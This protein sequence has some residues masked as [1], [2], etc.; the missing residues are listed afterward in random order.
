[1]RLVGD[2]EEGRP[3]PPD[4]EAVVELVRRAAAGVAAEC[5]LSLAEARLASALSNST[6]LLSRPIGPES[7]ALGEIRPAALLLAGA[8]LEEGRR[9]VAGELHGVALG[10]MLI[11]LRQDVSE[12]LEGVFVVRA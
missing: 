6:E 5:S 8:A 1:M 11:R 4:S 3:S 10:A 12:F 9:F 7:A 2:I